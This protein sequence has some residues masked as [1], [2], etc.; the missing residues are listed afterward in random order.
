MIRRL[1]RLSSILFWII[2]AAPAH[3]QVPVTG[4]VRGSVMDA[5]GGEALANVQILLVGA[6]YR[7]TSD[8]TGHFRIQAVAPGDYVLNASTVGYRLVKRSFHLDPGEVKDF[9]I[10]L[11]SDTFR[12]T[13]TVVAKVGP[14][15][16][17]RQDS[18]SVLVLAGND[19][20]NLASVLADDPLR[21]VQNL[22]GVSSNNDFDA[23]FSL[24]GADYSRIGLYLDGILLHVPFHT[25]EGQ[26]VS[27]S[28]TA[29]N[30]D[31]VEELE[32]QEG[33]FPVRFADRTA[34]I[35]DVRMRDG[36][37]TATTV[38]AF[39]SA[40]NAGFIAEGPAHKRGSWLLG[41]RKSYL[42]YILARTFPDTSLIFALED[43]QGRLTY[44]LTKKNNI[45][46]Y[47][48]ESYSGLDRSGNRAKLGTN[49]LMEAGYHYTLG[50]F[51]W[52]YAPTDKLLIVNHAAWMRE[53]YNNSSPQ[54]LPL[55]GGYYGE[56]VW[57]G[58]AT[59]FWNPKSP[60]DMGWSVRKIRDQGF[61]N[62]YQ[63]TTLTL[64]LLDRFDGTD[65]RVGG[66]AQQSWTLWSGH[67]YFTA[68]ARWDHES[69]GG[70]AAVSPQA[71]V[72]FAITPATRIQLG[73]GQYVQYPEVS[74]LTSVMGGR[75]LLPE[76]SN[77]VIAAIEQ[78]FGERTRVRAEFYN[79][80]DRDLIFRPLFDPRI[81]NGRILVPPLNPPYA[82]SIRGYA[83]GFEIFVQRSSANRATG[84]IS[85]AYG[86]TGMREGVTRQA[87]PSDYDQRHTV[88]VYGGYRLRPS[89]N[90]SLRWSYGSGFPM[91]GYLQKTGAT[92]SLAGSRNQL[93]LDP[94]MRADFRINKAWTHD[95]W[96]LTLYGEVVNLT[97]RA[98]YIFDILDGYNSKTGQAFL[99]LDKLFPI[100]PS[101]GLVFER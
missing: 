87:F 26:N 58:E 95:K 33:A 35:L 72:G 37:R 7:A 16:A 51:S 29:F 50:N 54:N 20:K 44:D 73:W 101:A 91:P 56:W 40:S 74:I 25:L 85:Y 64:R 34:G 53:K 86:R 1:R 18:P 3:G 9:E 61:A 92:Y 66:Y 82:N 94:Y 10:I 81:E 84:W 63:S 97:N 42:Q 45:S 59:W 69:L 23:R 13:E 67:L 19:A 24:R 89:V 14:F 68:G 90:L 15:E 52:R 75:W 93:R 88:N 96:K 39:A 47:I 21:A 38:R 31:M 12:L 27:G 49:S 22:P 5:R 30:G 70:S 43:V 57:N 11:S 77:H 17:V 71:S 98:N 99:T 65:M 32:L 78:R 46:L 83:R 2:A 48:L 36:S 28:G 79:R 62:R 80:A 100:L 76:R 6:T 41:A 55:G 60:L 4:E 8:D